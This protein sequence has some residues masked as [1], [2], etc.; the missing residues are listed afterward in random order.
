MRRISLA[1]VVTAVALIAVPSG[2]SAANVLIYGPSDSSELT[3][4][5]AT[6]AGHTASVASES[7]WAGLTTSDFSGYDAIVFGLDTSCESEGLET[8]VA[9]RGAWSP[10]V[11]GGIVASSFDNHEDNGGPNQVSELIRNEINFAVAGR[12][13]GLAAMCAYQFSEET[14]TLLDRFGT[15]TVDGEPR[16]DIAILDSSHPVIAGPPTLT[17]SG[18]SDWSNSTHSGYTSFPASFEVVALGEDG[19]SAEPVLIA[20]DPPPPGSCK[21][22][23]ATI[24][25]TEQD[26]VLTGTDGRDVIAALG[27]NDQVTSLGG[28]D[29]VCGAAG[30]DVLRGGKNKDKLLG[31]AGKDKLR[32][33]GGKDRLLGKGGKDKLNGGTSKDVCTGGKKDDTAKQCEVEKSI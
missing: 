21:G 33:Q 17:N 24:T 19:P 25:G 12:G 14:V 10:A 18:L 32:G 4:D 2:A 30:K 28:N 11:T 6:A 5:A 29:L 23:E 20:K 31:Q 8:A 22:Q 13:T 15:F 9:S 27:G 26:D 3:R 16:D 1:G 7:T